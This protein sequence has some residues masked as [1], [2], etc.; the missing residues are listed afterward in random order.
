LGCSAV[1]PSRSCSDAHFRVSAMRRLCPNTCRGFGAEPVVGTAGGHCEAVCLPALN[2]GLTGPSQIGRSVLLVSQSIPLC[3]RLQEQLPL[4]GQNRFG[5]RSALT[6]KLAILF[7]SN[8]YK[9]R[10]S[11]E[12]PAPKVGRGSEKPLPS[13]EE[14][15]GRR[16]RFD[17]ASPGQRFLV[18]CRR[19]LFANAAMAACGL[20]HGRGWACDL[21]DAGRSA[22]TS[23]AIL[24][25]RHCL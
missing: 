10:K 9:A 18:H 12:N 3:S 2:G 22:S 25:A 14:G 24:R 4:I 13:S 1:P 16:L 21:R 17:N 7:C 6:G 19:Q 11:S 8:R 23:T 15:V 5:Q 20:Q